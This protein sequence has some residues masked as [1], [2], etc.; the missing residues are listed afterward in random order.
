MLG[1][2]ALSPPSI[3]KVSE[4]IREFELVAVQ[5]VS[6][7]FLGCLMVVGEALAVADPTGLLIL[8]IFNV[9]SAMLAICALVI[10][11]SIMGIGRE[12]LYHWCR[13]SIV[14]GQRR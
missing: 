10:P 13:V 5:R 11:L 8:M 3:G 2:S 12:E 7:V 1:F 9:R 6:Y 14:T 4:S